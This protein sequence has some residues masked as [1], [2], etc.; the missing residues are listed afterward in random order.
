VIISARFQDDYKKILEVLKGRTN[1][2]FFVGG[3]VRDF[4]LKREFCDID[5]EVFDVEPDRFAALMQSIGAAGVGKSYFVYKLGNFD[6]SLPREE[7]KSGIGHKAFEVRWCNVPEAASKRRD[8]T[9]NSIM[10]N[11]FSGECL[12]FNNGIRDI[13]L[14]TIRHIDQD[15]FKEDSLRV[16]RA[17]RFSSQLGFKIAE[18][19]AALC[20]SIPLSD[21]SQERIAAEFN[22]MFHSDHRVRGVFYM[23]TL[24]IAEKILG[25]REVKLSLLRALKR[26]PSGYI[27]LYAFRALYGIAPSCFFVP[28]KVERKIVSMPLIPKRVSDRFLIRTALVM[29]LCEWGGTYILRL[30]ERAKELNIFENKFDPCVHATDLFNE[31]YKE[32]KELGTELKKRILR[33]VREYGK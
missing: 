18:E 14:K 1:R 12:D 16:L 4:I 7:S 23:F 8:F 2:A 10:I 20:R 31:G 3:A 6:I 26:L 17:M 29:P 19:T 24:W 25:I 9:I 21:L 15:R 32:G 11:I 22:I 28:K 27:N 13:E 5:I 30:Q 33:K